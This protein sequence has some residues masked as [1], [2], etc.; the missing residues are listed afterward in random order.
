M[1]FIADKLRV[2]RRQKLGV[3]MFG[4]NEIAST[5]QCRLTIKVTGDHGAGEAPPVGVR[6]GRRG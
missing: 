5:E 1:A 2:Q 3:V 6:V 4:E